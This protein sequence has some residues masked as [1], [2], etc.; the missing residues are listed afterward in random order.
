[1]HRGDLNYNTEFEK[2]SPLYNCNI[3][4][5]CNPDTVVEPEL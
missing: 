4:M 5:G 2:Q 1:M 3:N